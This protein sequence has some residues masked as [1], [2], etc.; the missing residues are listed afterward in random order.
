MANIKIAA[1]SISKAPDKPESLRGVESSHDLACSSSSINLINSLRPKGSLIVGSIG[2]VK[3]TKIIQ[4]AI[5]VI[6]CFLS[7]GIVFGYAALKPILIEEQIYRNY[8]SQAELDQ[9]IRVCV[10]QEIRLNLM[11]VVAVVGTNVSAQPVGA[12]LD[13]YGP[14]ICGLISSAFLLMGALLFAFGADTK[15]D[16][17]LIGYFFLAIGGAFTSMPY[18]HL[19]N[20]FPKNSGLILAMISGAFDSS[21]ALF[22]IYKDFYFQSHKSFGPKKFFLIYLIVPIFVFLVQLFYMP[23]LSYKSIG[24]VKEVKHREHQIVKPDNYDANERTV[25]L[26]A[27]FDNQD[28][29]A[30]PNS[31]DYMGFENARKQA[32]HQEKKNEISGVWGVMHGKSAKDQITSLWF[33]LITLFTVLQM[34]RINYFIATVHPQYEYILGSFKD[35]LEINAVFDTALPLGG[36]VGIPFIGIILDNISTPSVFSLILTSATIIGSLGCLPYK[37]AAYSNVLLFVLFRP[38]F[39]TALSDINAKIFG[40]TTFGTVYGLM[41]SISGL[42]NFVANGLDQLRYHTFRQNPIPINLLLI[43]VTFVAGVVLCC[44]VKLKSNLWKKNAIMES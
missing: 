18:F 31:V 15:F 14:R 2:T 36:L 11:F 9:N 27:E 28:S 6:N 42:F 20:T 3:S 44:Y 29:L 4:I 35:A 8:C 34:I 26:R 7:A 33:I 17:H 25:L 1:A 5:A 39:Y 22:L 16:G 21:S 13:K 38:F 40:F 12:I 19:S 10:Q 41:I 30:N 32:N 43:A 24:E 37:W 23:K